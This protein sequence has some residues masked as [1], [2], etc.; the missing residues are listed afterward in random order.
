MKYYLYALDFSL[1]LVVLFLV[2]LISISLNKNAPVDKKPQNIDQSKTIQAK[3][4]ENQA[5]GADLSYIV[6]RSDSGVK[7]ELLDE[8]G[9]SAG[10]SFIEN[11]LTDP[12]SG[13]TSGDPL[14]V[15]D[16]A[17]PQKGLYTLVTSG[18]NNY[19]L[20][21]YLY[22][23]NGEVKMQKI[24]GKKGTARIKIHFDKGSSQN[25]WIEKK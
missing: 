14:Q 11:P 17:K 6:I 12:V 15:L 19:T 10:Q 18:K 23:R 8:K 2:Y 3:K 1:L 21:F 16:Y 13:Q 20:D 25:S 7:L 22:D 9:N 24:V 5:S 4:I